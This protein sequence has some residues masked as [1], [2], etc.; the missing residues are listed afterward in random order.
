[1]MYYA[2]A[3]PGFLPNASCLPLLGFALLYLVC[4]LACLLRN[5]D[6]YYDPQ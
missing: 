5:S 6:R 1:M 3:F 4:N 2:S